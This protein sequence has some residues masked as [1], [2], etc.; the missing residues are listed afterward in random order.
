MTGMQRLI[1]SLERGAFRGRGGETAMCRP[2]PK[3]SA[4]ALAEIGSLAGVH[5]RAELVFPR[6]LAGWLR[7]RF[8]RHG[9]SLLSQRRHIRYGNVA[10]A[11]EL[12]HWLGA[13]G[14]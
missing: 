10:G 7:S 8:A 12:R 1:S 13:Q 4:V 2:G 11:V 9:L 14:I 3:T 6:A 5:N